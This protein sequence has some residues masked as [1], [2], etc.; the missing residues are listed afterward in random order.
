MGGSGAGAGP[1][2]E[3]GPKPSGPAGPLIGPRIA[4][5]APEGAPAAPGW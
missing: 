3:R 5:L 4:I 2:C 1:A